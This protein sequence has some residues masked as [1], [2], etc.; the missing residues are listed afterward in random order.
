[1]CKISKSVDVHAI[2]E[3]LEQI[4]AELPNVEEKVR[5]TLVD[6]ERYISVTAVIGNKVLCINFM[7]SREEE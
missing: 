3:R 7:Q 2:K 6:D 4:I 1:M 5:A